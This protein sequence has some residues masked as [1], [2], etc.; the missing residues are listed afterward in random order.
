MPESV[1]ES[2]TSTRGD[3]LSTKQPIFLKVPTAGTTVGVTVGKTVDET[4]VDVAVEPDEEGGTTIKAPEG[5]TL[6]SR[7]KHAWWLA[8]VTWST[9]RPHVSKNFPEPRRTRTDWGNPR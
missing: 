7:L 8:P 2:A 3:V 4:A 1:L 5:L 9:P 6:S